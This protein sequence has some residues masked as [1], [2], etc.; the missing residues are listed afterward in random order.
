LYWCN[1]P[2]F[3]FWK[4]RTILG[5]WDSCWI[6][7]Y[8]LHALGPSY[9]SLLCIY[10]RPCISSPRVCC[11]LLC[12]WISQCTKNKVQSS[13]MQF[14]P[15]TV[16]FPWILTCYLD[17]PDAFFCSI[18]QLFTVTVMWPAFLIFFSF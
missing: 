16:A 2:L 15:L 4:E 7:H 5:I 18:L 10:W 1:L 14:E 3:P 9:E 12:L 17:A 6:M 8:T 13:G 11:C